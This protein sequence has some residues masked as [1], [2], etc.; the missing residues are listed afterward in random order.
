MVFFAAS[1]QSFWQQAVAQCTG[2][3]GPTVHPT[4]GADVYRSATL[5]IAVA[6]AAAAQEIWEERSS[7]PSKWR[8]RLL[9]VLHV[10]T[11][12]SGPGCSVGD[13]CTR[14]TL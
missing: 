14:D 13:A 1:S 11:P 7:H 12:Y 6:A 8:W 5:N 2:D 9:G 4:V 3:K 10:A